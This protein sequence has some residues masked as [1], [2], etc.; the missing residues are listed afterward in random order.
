MYNNSS[1]TE[2]LHTGLIGH[3]YFQSTQL[4]PAVAPHSYIQQIQTYPITTWQNDFIACAWVTVLQAMRW[5]LHE[6]LLSHP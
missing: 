2:D 5:T 1:T 4:L 6:H 3:T